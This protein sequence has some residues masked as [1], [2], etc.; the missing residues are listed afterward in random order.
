VLAFVLGLAIGAGVAGAV[1]LA[2][3]QA[4]T[5]TTRTTATTQPTPTIY[6]VVGLKDVDII[7]ELPTND[8]AIIHT[9][10]ATTYQLDGLPVSLRA[11]TPGARI[12]VRG[13][14]GADGT[15]TAGR[16]AI[17]PA[18]IAGVIQSIHG[19]TM[20]VMAHTKG[21]FTIVLSPAT[22]ITSAQAHQSLGPSALKAGATIQA[23]GTFTPTGAF[24]PVIV[25]VG[26]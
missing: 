10:R 25:V 20:V 24:T 12:T 22:K 9:S 18:V 5:N 17:L 14:H 26:S 21:A 16:I 11:L 7:A 13:K 15:I 19:D 2:A 1:V 4:P 23:T 8:P 3:S 6:T